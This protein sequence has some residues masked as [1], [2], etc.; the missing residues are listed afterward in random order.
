MS[1]MMAFKRS[2]LLRSV[3]AAMA[4]GGLLAGCG[5]GGGGG[6]SVGVGVGVGI[7]F[8]QPEVAALSLALTRVGPEAVEVDWSDDPRAAS[9][10]VLRD[11]FALATVT[12]TSLVDA[13]V[14]FDNTYCYQVEGHDGTGQLVAA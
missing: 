7:P 13:S 3:V 9:F 8:Q 2:F 12:S 6:A 1:C 5:G 4:L 10:L 14:V 11:G